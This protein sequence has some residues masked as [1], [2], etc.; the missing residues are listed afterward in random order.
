LGARWGLPEVL[1]LGRVLIFDP[2]RQRPRENAARRA[3]KGSALDVLA[4]AG[5]LAGISSA[6]FGPAPKTVCVASFHSGQ[7]RHSSAARRSLASERPAGM[8]SAAEVVSAAMPSG[9]PFGVSHARVGPEGCLASGFR[10]LE[11]G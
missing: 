2:A 7:P 11:L 10:A 6:F 3:D 4:V 5:L 9:Y 8:N 1:D